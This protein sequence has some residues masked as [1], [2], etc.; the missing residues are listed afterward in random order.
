MAIETHNRWPAQPDAAK[1]S[2]EVDD[3]DSDAFE[4]RGSGGSRLVRRLRAIGSIVSSSLTRRIVF[5]NLAAM[6]ALV[7]GILYLN[8]FKEGL[9]DARVESLLIQGEIIGAAI[10]ASATVDTDS[11]VIDPEKLLELEAG[12]SLTPSEPDSLDFPINPEDVAPILRRLIS[13]TKTRARIYDRE[14]ILILDSRHLYSRGQIL[15]FDLPAPQTESENWYDWIASHIRRWL[16]RS[17]LPVYQ[18]LG[19]M[20]GKEYPEVAAALNGT[21]LSVVRV[22]PEGALIV[23]VAV[24][25]QR[26]R[27]VHGALLLSTQGGDIDEIVHAERLAIVRTFVVA[28]AVALVLS[29]LLAQTIAGPV[30]RLAS[31]AERVR[32]GVKSRTEIPDFTK[33]QDEIGHLS[34]AL[35]A[36]TNAL[37]SRMEAIERFAADVAHEIKNPLTSLRSAVETLPLAKK[38]GDRDRLLDI[39]KHDVGRL[40]RLI[41][42]ISDASR[43]DSEL[44]KGDAKPLDLEALLDA[45]VKLSNEM[46]EDNHPHVVLEIRDQDRPL[47]IQGHDSRLGQV[48]HNLIDNAKSFSPSDEPIHISTRADR[49]RIELRVDDTG[50]GIPPENLERIFE[51]FYTDRGEGAPFGQNSGLGLSISRQIVEGHGGTLHAEN[52]I[53]ADG[54]RIGARF[55]LRLP[56]A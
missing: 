20:E 19:P 32:V 47:I 16:Q 40:D 35:R 24:P 28:A 1:A 13:P 54:K 10:A 27:A 36:M 30:R 6:L 51:R 50:P 44:A 34:G 46:L 3:S 42:D 11:I 41:S 7:W 52:R 53:G 43:L 37:Y 26:F 39:L 9:I 15:R 56:R 45:V 12:E 4:L 23:S 5:L 2:R 8:Q 18:E 49:R 29:I 55:V 48:L 38:E 21:P 25:V 31:A 22:N 33:R 14:G 17:D